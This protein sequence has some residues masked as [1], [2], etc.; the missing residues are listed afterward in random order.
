MNNKLDEMQK[1]LENA[2]AKNEIHNVQMY[3]LRK[4]KYFLDVCETYITIHD[5]ISHTSKY[6][7]VKRFRELYNYFTYEHISNQEK[8]SYIKSLNNMII[9][10]TK[11]EKE[12]LE[13]LAI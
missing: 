11:Q 8:M 4:Q 7:F 6:N 10:M 5:K 13:W 9:I 1:T 12:D 3:I 2:I